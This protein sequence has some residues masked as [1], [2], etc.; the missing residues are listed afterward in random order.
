MLKKILILLMAICGTAA[1]AN[2]NLLADPG[3]ESPDASGGDL[4]WVDG[5]L[6][7][8]DPSF[9]LVT[10]TQ[11]ESG[12]Q[13]LKMFG[14]WVIGEGV[15]LLQT[16]AASEGQTW[17]A[18]VSSFNSGSDPMGTGNFCAMKIEFLDAGYGPVGGSWLAGINVF[19]VWVADEYSPLD[20]W[21]RFGV[22]TAPAPTGTAFANYVLL[23]VQGYDGSDPWVPSGGSVFLDNAC[24]IPEPTTL[25][26]LGF[27]VLGV[28][29]KGRA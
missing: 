7:F 20:T 6:S 27:G 19:E 29:R 22:G 5:W 28:L 21:R 8:G 13:S 11:A 25:A 18:E 16:F 12:L 23:E 3:F 9:S 10:Q 15:G 4:N 1:V 14:P 17:V 24:F 26:I 2:A